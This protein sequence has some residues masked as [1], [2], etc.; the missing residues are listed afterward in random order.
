MKSLP[1]D[2]KVVGLHK[3]LR[4]CNT[5]QRLFKACHLAMTPLKY[6]RSLDAR[7]MAQQ[8]RINQVQ[9]ESRADLENLDLAK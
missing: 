7:N 4:H 1:M 2:P 9:M 5:V 3:L 8:V 6:T